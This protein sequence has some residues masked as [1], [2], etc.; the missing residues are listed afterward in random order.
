[1]P[2]VRVSQLGELR[3]D[4]IVTFLTVTR[5]ESI[6]G[7]ARAL[8]VTPSQVSKAVKRLERHL[9]AQLFAR[10]AR[11]VTVSA[12]G[13]RIKP[14]LE[15]IV[16]R[17]S[18]LRAAELAEELTVAAPSF[19]NALF[20]PR[21]AKLL[22]GYRIRGVELPPALVRL[23]A[24]ENLFDLALTIGVERLPATWETT[25]IGTMTKGLFATPAVAKR[26]G[27]KPVSSDALADL[28]FVGPIYHHDGRFVVADE[29]CPIAATRRLGHEAQTVA[30]ALELAAGTGQLVFAPNIV[31]KPYVMRGELVEIAVAGWDVREQLFVACNGDRVLAKARDAIV[32]GLRAQLALLS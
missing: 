8:A 10:G 30:L 3:F 32:P 25:L 1:V 23:Y 4:D 20:L 11:G 24:A 15:D 19:L 13:G 14:L 18:G 12:T 2:D 28:P 5:S 31:A 9:G 17:V 26:L 16:R 29:G 22:P 7:A 6:S 21:I 27:R